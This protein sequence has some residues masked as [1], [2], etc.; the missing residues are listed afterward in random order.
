MTPWLLRRERNFLTIRTVNTEIDLPYELGN[1]P[2][3]VGSCENEQLSL[4]L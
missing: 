2:I 4:I 3:S 1:I